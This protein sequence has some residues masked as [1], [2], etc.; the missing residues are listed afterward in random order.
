MLLVLLLMAG[1][2]Y[3][4]Y[5]YWL[6]PEEN[7]DALALIPEDAVF[8][9]ETSEP[10]DAWNTF[11]KSSLWQHIKQFTPLGDVGKMADNL[12]DIIDR[13]KIL[14]NAFGSRKVFISA[15]VT[16]P[17]DYD[18]LF[19]CDMQKSAKFD[20]VKKGI[21]ELLKTNGWKHAELT[22]SEIVINKFSDGASNLHMS[23]VGNQLICSFNEKIIRSSLQQRKQPKLAKDN[24]FIEATR[25]AAEGNICRIYLNHR[26]ATR[27]LKVYMDDVSSIEPVFGSMHFSGL[28]ADLRGDLVKFQGSTSINDSLPSYIRA[29]ALSGKSAF[30]APE[31]LSEKAAF[32]MGFGF[33]SF[34][35]FYENLKTV[36]KTEQKEWEEFEKNRRLMEK[37]L[38]FSLEEDLLGWIGE[39][40]CLAQ[41]EQERVI[42]GKINN[43]IAMR[44]TSIDKAREKLSEIEKRIR[45]RTPIKFEKA[46]YHGHDIHYLEI[47]G[48]FKLLFGKL[49]GKI[50][51]PYYTFLGDYVVFSD[52]IAT[53]LKTVDD[54]E[55]KKTLANRS[56]FKNFSGNYSSE[57]SLHVYLNMPMYFLDMKGILN[58]ESWKSTFENRQYVVCFNQFGLQLA[59]D[60][61]GLETRLMTE[62]VKPTPETLTIA[63]K[64]P[65]NIEEIEEQ[66]SMSDADV[67]ILEFIS[68]SVKKEFYESGKIK[69]IANTRN[70]DLHGRYVEYWE[71]GEIKVKGK[72]QKGEKSGIWRFYDEEGELVRKQKFRKNPD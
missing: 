72:Y 34:N 46:E 25:N 68:G 3:Y 7:V 51:K 29:L 17:D 12:T 30:R 53:L 5:R 10:V 19:V 40:V 55:D 16:K 28:S 24:K 14:F 62:F 9:V 70:E 38:G 27:F 8:V 63:E 33:H 36:L 61:G 21:I 44:A 69:W 43:V 45:K 37:F 2:G 67:F 18:F 22:E 56:D 15:H 50:E 13:N 39:E 41:Y 35:K 23:F 26:T 49:F 4:A 20:E 71:N 54:F 65:L 11:S 57:S 52:D 60:N 1:G 48:L 42:G 31:V 58:P 59:S 32:T 64:P 47:K 6:T 66:D